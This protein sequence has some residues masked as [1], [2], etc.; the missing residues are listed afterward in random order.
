MLGSS[1]PVEHAASAGVRKT[2]TPL[3]VRGPG[4]SGA[5]R[6]LSS[7]QAPQVNAQRVAALSQGRQA[8]FNY[9]LAPAAR[10]PPPRHVPSA[11]PRRAPSGR[12]GYF[13][14]LSTDDTDD[15]IDASSDLEAS[16]ATDSPCVT[17]PAA[18]TRSGGGAPS[19]QPSRACRGPSAAPLAQ[20][21]VVSPP[22]NSTGT[23]SSPSTS[24]SPSSNINHWSYDS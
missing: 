19:R 14:P 11:A 7:R 5:I 15:D 18:R 6:S 4:C 24:S 23:D 2:I 1:T 21:R 20:A 13:S 8:L 17:P 16:I 3:S 9:P 10:M 12:H 22:D